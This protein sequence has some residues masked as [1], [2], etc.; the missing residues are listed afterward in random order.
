MV[1]MMDLINDISESILQLIDYLREKYGDNFTQFKRL[2]LYRRPPYRNNDGDQSS[3]L[4]F[5]S[6][7]IKNKV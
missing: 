1:L 4:V 6:V 3:G 2:S 7:K 5:L